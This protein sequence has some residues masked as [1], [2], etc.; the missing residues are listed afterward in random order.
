MYIY[1]YI[2]IL[3]FNPKFPF[4]KQTREFYFIR[5]DSKTKPN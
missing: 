1:I 5:R 2:Y 4:Q 3:P